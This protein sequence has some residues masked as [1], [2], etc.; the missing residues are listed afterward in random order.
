MFNFLFHDLVISGGGGIQKVGTLEICKLHPPHLLVR[1]R[2][3]SLHRILRMSEIFIKF[4]YLVK[5]IAQFTN[6]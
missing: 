6:F 2:T 5:V 4:A 1:F 3:L